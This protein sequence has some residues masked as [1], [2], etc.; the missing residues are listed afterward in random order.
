MHT[1]RPPLLEDGLGLAQ[2]PSE[3]RPALEWEDG[4]QPGRTIQLQP[5]NGSYHMVFK[6]TGPDLEV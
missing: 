3:S 4:S 6:A 5:N 2:S 1:L